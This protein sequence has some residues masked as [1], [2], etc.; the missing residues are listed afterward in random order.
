MGRGLLLAAWFR[1]VRTGNFQKAQI[2]ESLKII[3]S[4]ELLAFWVISNESQFHSFISENTDFNIDIKLDF[5]LVGDNNPKPL[6]EID[7][8]IQI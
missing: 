2:S 8:F 5:G 3:Y 4:R 7:L 1:N 6:I